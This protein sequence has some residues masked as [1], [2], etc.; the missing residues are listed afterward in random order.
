[1]TADA[2]A[3]APRLPSPPLP[4]VP[5]FRYYRT[6]NSLSVRGREGRAKNGCPSCGSD[7][8]SWK[9]HGSVQLATCLAEDSSFYG[10]GAVVAMGPVSGGRVGDP[11]K[12]RGES[13][14]CGEGASRPLFRRPRRPRRGRRDIGRSLFWHRLAEFRSP[15]Q[16]SRRM[17]SP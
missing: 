9:L 16:S 4:S 2:N 8:F 15:P 13:G 10:G 1:M 12:W 6:A 17:R 5:P 3:T 7:P 14:G 11:L